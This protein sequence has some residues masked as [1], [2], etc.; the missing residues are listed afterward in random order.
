MIAEDLTRQTHAD[1]VLPAERLELGL[2]GALGL[3]VDELH[4][5]GGTPRVAAAGM[6]LIDAGVF[7]EREDE[8]FPVRDLERSDVFDGQSRHVHQ[9][10]GPARRSTGRKNTQGMF[11]G[12]PK[13][14]PDVF[15]PSYT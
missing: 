3:A 6:E 9:C 12:I 2:R 15:F 11:S 1:G 5:A 13:S 10:S 8:A 7:L 4:A 14:I